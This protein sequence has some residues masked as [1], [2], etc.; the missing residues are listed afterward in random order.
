MS[1]SLP[2]VRPGLTPRPMPD[3]R[4]R[5]ARALSRYPGVDASMVAH[6][7]ADLGLPNTLQPL[8][9]SINAPHDR[10][11]G[12]MA[13]RGPTPVS[14]ASELRHNL[15]GRPSPRVPQSSFITPAPAQTRQARQIDGAPCAPQPAANHRLPAELSDHI[16]VQ[17]SGT[18]H[19]RPPSA[20][21]NFADSLARMWTSSAQRNERER[22]DSTSASADTRPTESAA[23]EYQSGHSSASPNLFSRGPRGTQGDKFAH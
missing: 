20:V 19:S 14:V 23:H 18:F 7:E 22:A 10:Q 9:T 17:E 3:G 21:R 11:H 12:P 15:F 8:Q 4:G 16:D 13:P 1:D 5:D 2:P 6:A